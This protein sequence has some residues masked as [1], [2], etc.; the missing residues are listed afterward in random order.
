M[1]LQE[2]IRKIL[3]EETEGTSS[4]IGTISS[5]FNISD[6]LKDEVITFIEESNCKKIEF[7]NF[8]FPVLGLALHTGV[9]INNKVLSNNLEYVLFVIFHEIAHQYQFKKYGEDLMYDCYI[10][11]IS[12]D[13]AAR[14][15][16]QTEEVADEFAARKIRQLQKKDLL[17]KGFIPP[18]M[19]KN[20][21]LQQILMMVKQNKNQMRSMN[22]NS[23][24]KVSEYFYNMVKSDL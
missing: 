13:E 3:K 6:E 20:L 19:Y 1:N 15:M 4:F 21:P 23:P 9:L 12:D 5:K 24:E 2:R 14:F 11:E 18:Q 17:G 7:S 16:K 8:K 22:I 10:G